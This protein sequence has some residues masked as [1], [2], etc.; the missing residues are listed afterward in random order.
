MVG[1]ETDAEHALAQVG[2]DPRAALAEADAIVARLPRPRTPHDVREVATAH[3]AAGLA[4]RSLSDPVE[5]ERR[6]RRGVGLAERHGLRDVAA[7]VRMSLA[8][9]LSESGRT[10]AAL[11]CTDEALEVLTDG[12]GARVRVIRALVFHRAG[13]LDD[14]LHEYA[15]ALP[16]LRRAGDEL[17]EAR[18][19]H[20]RAQILAESGDTGAALNDLEWAYARHVEHGET[21]DAADTLWNM[22]SVLAMSG[23]VPTALAMFDRAEAAWADLDR[24]ERWLYRS[25]VL[26]GVGL[27]GEAAVNARLAVDHLAGRGW[28][29]LESEARLQW[30]L[31]MLADPAP[32]LAAIHEQAGHARRLLR[33]QNRPEWSAVAD[34]VLTKS[35]LLGS[36]SIRHL[37]RVEEVADTLARAGYSAHS[38][39]LRITAGRFALAHGHTARGRDILA[40]LA[41]GHRS[42][43]WGVRARASFASGL[44]AEADGALASA[45]R[46]LRSAWSSVEAQMRTLGAT[47][48][49]AGAALHARSLVT[50]GARIALASGSTARLFDWGERGRVA[51]LRYSPATA[52]R[53]P[54]LARALTQL[55]WARVAE[56]EAHLEGDQDKAFD[57][58]CRR[59]ESEVVRITRSRAGAVTGLQTVRAAEL[60]SELGHEAF[61]QLVDVD[62]QLWGITITAGG[63]RRDPLGATADAS[64]ALASVS[65]AMSRILS[66]F[67]T[68]STRSALVSAL[69]RAVNTLDSLALAPLAARLGD[70]DLVICPPASLAATPWSL[71]PTCRSRV[72]TVAPSATL[73]CQAR[74]RPARSGGAVLAVSGPG[75]PAART[76]AEQVASLYPG[77]RALTGA[78]A[79]VSRLL[80]LAPDA[81]LLHLAAHGRLRKD[82][83]LFSELQL[84]DGPLM[85]YDLES[86][87]RVPPCVVLSACS[88]GAGHAVVADETL[89][90][91]W[92]LLGLGSSMVIAPLYVVPDQATR[93]LMVDVH[94]RTVDGAPL[95][96]ALSQAQAAADPDDP[97]A[98]AVAAAFLAY[99]AIRPGVG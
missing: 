53:D 33:R 32:D 17:W 52:P 13:R 7:E 27:I 38:A 9:V 8:F 34:Y 60:R 14:A 91:A 26:F 10:R 81:D 11:S 44:L 63:T 48:L 65:F 15:L 76:E 40:P 20:N 54:E 29:S 35:A 36:P 75:L 64:A 70:Q 67:G 4:L 94:R 6:M 43:T 22:G 73:W 23:D 49:R 42:A 5:A 97:V 95:P 72:V 21:A 78:D 92:T 83:P 79:Q 39:D 89:G 87:S 58:A 82:N 69:E 68:A 45:D 90:L 30:A 62:G 74:R 24:P 1:A 41:R 96:V 19:R 59:A 84:V 37:A 85:G 55:R 28:I 50:A 93:H 46:H 80:E 66:G 99:G 88:S 2:V 47:E 31:C 25:D 56:E 57:L 98:V 86:L 3:R 71:L 61:V 77:A 51:T 12:R 18:L 16:E